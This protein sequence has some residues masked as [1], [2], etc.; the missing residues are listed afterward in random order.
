MRILLV[1]HGDPDYDTDSLTE[2]GVQEAEALASRADTL[3]R[4]DFCYVSPLGRARQTASYCLK[5]LGMEAETKDWLQE[6]PARLRPEEAPEEFSAA[7][8]VKAGPDG[9]LEPRIVWD[10]YPAYYASH[11]ELKDREGWRHSAIA[12]HSDV[13]ACYD[14]VTAGFDGLLAEHGYIRDGDEYLA[15]RPNRDRIAMFCHFGVTCVMLS[16]LMNLS[17]FVLLQSACILPTGVTEIVT[18]ERQ[19][20]IAS[21]RILRMG[22]LT[23]L[24]LSGVEPSFSARFCETFDSDERH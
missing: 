23:H 11:P 8:H 10:I 22:D 21:F 13:T 6:F 4:P 15:V 18:E 2:Q 3:L 5:V 12:R 1:R 9:K 14:R 16:H 24:V 17:P 7:Y 19:R 20:G